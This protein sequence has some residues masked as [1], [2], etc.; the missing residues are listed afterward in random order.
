MLAVNISNYWYILICRC[1]RLRAIL[2][3]LQRVSHHIHILCLW[4]DFHIRRRRWWW[5]SYWEEGCQGSDQPFGKL[6]FSR[7]GQFSAV[8]TTAKNRYLNTKTWSLLNPDR[9]ILCP[10]LNQSINTALVCRHIHCQQLPIWLL[11]I[12][13]ILNDPVTKPRLT[14]T[15]SSV[16]PLHEEVKTVFKNRWRSWNSYRGKFFQDK[17][18][19]HTRTKC[20][21]ACPSG[22]WSKPSTINQLILPPTCIIKQVE[23]N[24]SHRGITHKSN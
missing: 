20:L 4:P 9:L 7:T 10:K 1:H 8:I 11:L 16:C 17:F 21:Q 23:N 3:F 5:W 22:I 2:T 14:R 18:N 13:Q 6:C 19:S 24:S 12:D 15:I